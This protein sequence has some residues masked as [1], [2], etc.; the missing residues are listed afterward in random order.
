MTPEQQAREALKRCWEAVKDLRLAVECIHV[1]SVE[2]AEEAHKDWRDAQR[3]KREADAEFD[4]IVRDHG[5]DA[6]AIAAAEG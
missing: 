4:R 3:A 6:A 2:H 1:D 5:L